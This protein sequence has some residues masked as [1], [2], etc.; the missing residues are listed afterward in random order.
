MGLQKSQQAINILPMKALLDRALLVITAIVAVSATG[1]G[2]H[3][4]SST[5]EPVQHISQCSSGQ[6]APWHCG[7]YVTI[8]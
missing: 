6:K 1:A 7:Y 5:S 8:Q 2:V 3:Y 4:V